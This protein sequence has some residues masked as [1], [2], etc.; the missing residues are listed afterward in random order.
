[1]VR[2]ARS[3]FQPSLHRKLVGKCAHSLHI[4]SG[5]FTF[6]L[7]PAGG[8]SGWCLR[9]SSCCGVVFGWPSL[10]SQI[11]EPNHDKSWQLKG[12]MLKFAEELFNSIKLSQIAMILHHLNWFDGC[13]QQTSNDFEVSVQF[14]LSWSLNVFVARVCYGLPYLPHTTTKRESLVQRK[15]SGIPCSATSQPISGFWRSLRQAMA[16]CS[17]PYVKMRFYDYMYVWNNKYF[18]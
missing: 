7:V 8:S 14:P 11:I 12:Y 2:F 13:W 17:S 6:V 5:E 4:M 9:R 10:S 15:D 3:A 16:R 18:N 1:M